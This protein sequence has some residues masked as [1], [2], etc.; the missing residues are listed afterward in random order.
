MKKRE[1]SIIRNFAISCAVVLTGCSSTPALTTQTVEVPVAVP[2]V[3]A[4]PTRPVYEF[5]QL[6]ATA[7]DGDKV[8]A[9][10]RDWVRYRKYA[11]QLEASL[12]SCIN[13]S[14]AIGVFN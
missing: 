1:L 14:P 9:L 11:V 2:C 3:N 5:D 7:S 13:L 4:M 12:I 8:L 6:P 10:V